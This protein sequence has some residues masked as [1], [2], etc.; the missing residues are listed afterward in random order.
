MYF[1]ECCKSCIHN[2]TGL[3]PCMQIDKPEVKDF[4]QRDTEE[5]ECCPEWY[6]EC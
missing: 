5:N 4:L 6:D 1:K 3:F 2:L